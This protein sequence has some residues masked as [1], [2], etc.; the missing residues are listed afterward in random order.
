MSSSCKILICLVQ[1]A[2]RKKC[3]LLIQHVTFIFMFALIKYIFDCLWLLSS[4]F[5]FALIYFFLLTNTQVTFL[6]HSQIIWCSPSLLPRPPSRSLSQVLT[7]LSLKR[8]NKG[9]KEN[10]TASLVTQA[11]GSRGWG[12]TGGQGPEEGGKTAPTLTRANVCDA[13][14]GLSRGPRAAERGLKITWSCERKRPSV[15]PSCLHTLLMMRICEQDVKMPVSQ[16]RPPFFPYGPAALLEDLGKE[17]RLLPQWVL[18]RPTYPPSWE[19]E[20]MREP[21]HLSVPDP[22]DPPPKQSGDQHPHAQ[23]HW[24]ENSGLKGPQSSPKKM[25]RCTSMYPTACWGYSLQMTGDSFRSRA[26]RGV[27]RKGKEKVFVSWWLQPPQ[28]LMSSSPSPRDML[29]SCS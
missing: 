18:F 14:E 1:N 16:V 7:F 15:I 3:C 2:C 23:G 27:S 6:Y 24:A 26:G 19:M 9:R 25:Q 5:F 10:K 20:V 13:G 11:R 12:R 17:G 22:T 4:F 21:Q 29:N 8:Q 28:A